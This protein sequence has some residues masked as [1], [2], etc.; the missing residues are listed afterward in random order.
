M[1]FVALSAKLRKQLGE[2]MRTCTDARVV[3]RAE[4]ILWLAN[5]ESVV[6]V[7]E[8]LQVERKTIYNWLKRFEDLVGQSI[9]NRLKS[10]SRPGRPSDKSNL[11][12]KVAVE[13]LK[14]KPSAY[15]YEFPVWTAPLIRQHLKRNEGVLVSLRTIRRVLRD[16]DL[17]Y[18]RPRYTLARR[19]ATW[20]QSKGGSRKV[21]EIVPGW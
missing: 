20:Q 6:M 8:R 18:K 1:A 12:R 15:G 5:G 13:I 3:R 19:S 2:I 16:L 14:D 11:V 17:R 7:A 9:E 10:D 21:W 4:A